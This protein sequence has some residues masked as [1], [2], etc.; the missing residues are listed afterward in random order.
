MSRRGIGHIAAN[1]SSITNCGEKKIVGST[2]DGEGVTLRT[3]R[4]DVK[5]VL[6]SV[7]RMSMGGTAAPGGMKS[8]S[9]NEKMG[10][11]TRI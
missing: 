5:K 1:G 2:G 7:H 4:S 3:Q 9:Q 10:Q 6:G 8:Y 11:E